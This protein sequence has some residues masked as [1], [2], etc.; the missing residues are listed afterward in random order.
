MN[1]VSFGELLSFIMDSRIN[2][3]AAKPAP[4]Q[5]TKTS[6]L[7]GYITP[8]SLARMKTNGG[9]CRGSVPLH[10]KKSATARVPVYVQVPQ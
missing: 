5:L 10:S 6:V 4:D 9:N 2:L 8:E 1:S 3:D 7:L